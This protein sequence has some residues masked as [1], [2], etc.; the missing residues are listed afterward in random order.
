MLQKGNVQDTGSRSRAEIIRGRRKQLG[1]TQQDIAD[2]VGVNRRL[3]SEVEN[4]S[5]SVSL[6]HLIAICE[7]VGLD[8]L[9][10]AKYRDGS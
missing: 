10:T 2:Y 4:G 1:R 6:K 3:V 7:A 8:L 5:E 9:I